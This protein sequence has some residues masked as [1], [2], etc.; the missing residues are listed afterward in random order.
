MNSNRKT[1]PIRWIVQVA[2][3]GAA[4]AVVMFLEFPIPFLGPIFLRFDFSDIPALIGAFA[5][6][7]LAGVGIE[8]L[9]VTLN[10]LLEGSWSF[11]VGE[12]ANFLIGVAFVFPASL[13]YTLHKTRRNALIGMG[14]GVVSM[15]IAGALLN[16]YLLLPVYAAW[17]NLT[18]EALILSQSEAL[19]YVIDV[20]TGILLGIVPFNLFKGLVI[21][22]LVMLL[23]KRV[24]PLIKGRD[25]E[26]CDVDTKE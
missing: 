13:I 26:E 4:A 9:K 18:P 1:K 10:L 22:I 20:P 5:L 24:S 23:Y 16:L 25:E 14:V 17:L 8:A 15:V 19:P 11:S 7:P 3:L 12:L 21:S 2:I 6:G